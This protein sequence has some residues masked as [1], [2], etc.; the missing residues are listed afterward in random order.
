MVVPMPFAESTTYL[1]TPVDFLRSA[2]RDRLPQGGVIFSDGARRWSGAPPANA[3]STNIISNTLGRASATAMRSF[4]R[5]LHAHDPAR[6]DAIVA[7]DLPSAWIDDESDHGVDLMPVDPV[8]MDVDED[9]STTTSS[10]TTTSVV[11]PEI[12][13][14]PLPP[15]VEAAAPSLPAPAPAPTTPE[16]S[17]RAQLCC[18]HCTELFWIE[19]PANRITR[20]AHCI[21]CG[22]RAQ[23][24]QGV[25]STP[26]A[27]TNSTTTTTSASSS[28]TAVLSVA[29]LPAVVHDPAPAT[30]RMIDI[31]PPIPL[32]ALVP[33]AS[34][35]EEE[36]GQVDAVVNTPHRA[37]EI[38]V[39]A[40]D[41]DDFVPD[42]GD[43]NN[44]SDDTTTTSAEVA[45]DE[46]WFIPSA[47]PFQL[48][49][50]VGRPSR[51]RNPEPFPHGL[52]PFL[53][54][55]T[56]PAQSSSSSSSSSSSAA[57]PAAAAP[58][59]T[60]SPFARIM[61]DYRREFGSDLPDLDRLV[62]IC[63]SLGDDAEHDP[64]D[65]LL[66]ASSSSS[67]PPPNAFR[68]GS[69]LRGL[70]RLI[71]TSHRLALHPDPAPTL[72]KRKRDGD[73]DAV[74]R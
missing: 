38:V 66:A 48:P 52:P 36:E 62:T 11:S 73:D 72:G 24:V 69:S 27:A 46:D 13:D 58:S 56:P 2:Y 17:L 1:V 3:F 28:T 41:M 22:Q 54:P 23:L 19:I 12:V 35:D 60:D 31:T 16:Q 50:D 20:L 57:A 25:F 18:D 14:A 45:V 64:N 15:T 7:L 33:D 71:P 49:R 51:P 47:G 70:R 44:N 39:S 43:N 34:D 32:P 74:G 68:S 8:H 30:V 6:L 65:A 59:T 53:R 9:Q 10:T 63:P 37:A 67:S 29:P 5:H 42:L 61:A 55:W 21:Y 26:A 40:L 4:Y